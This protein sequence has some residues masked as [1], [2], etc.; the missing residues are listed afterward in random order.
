MQEDSQSESRSSF[1]RTGISEAALKYLAVAV[2]F[3]DHAA[4]TFLEVA[5]TADGHRMFAVIPN[6]RLLDRILRGIGRIAFPI[7]CFFLV[8]GFM[9]TRNRLKYLGRLL[10]YGT[11]AEIPFML[12]IFGNTRSLHLDT[13][14]ELAIGLVTI[15][16]MEEAEKR[17][18]GRRVLLFPAWLAIL[19][20]GCAAAHYLHADYGWGGILTIA[21]FYV[22][23]HNRYLGLPGAWALLS[24]YNSFEIWSFPAFFLLDRYNHERGRQSKYFFYLFYPGHLLLLYLIRRA[25][26]GA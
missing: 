3:I 10:F 8:E 2:M 22:F 6:G 26:F 12:C 20:A 15:W 14:F 16:G 5:R 17:L 9:R 19:A 7:F 23:R 11:L 18:G 25:V 4:C 13:M 1:L 24:Y 21:V